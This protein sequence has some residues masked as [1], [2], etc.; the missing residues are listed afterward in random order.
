MK[1]GTRVRAV[2]RRTGKGD[3]TTLAIEERSRHDE[4]IGVVAKH[5]DSH[6][7]CYEVAFADGTAW[8]DPE[9]L[10]AVETEGTAA[11]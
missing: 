1:A 9:E 3:Y 4:Q 10:T 2:C 5:S 11:P 8:F 6:G 7:L